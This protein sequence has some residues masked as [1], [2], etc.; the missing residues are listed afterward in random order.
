MITSSHPAFAKLATKLD[1]AGRELSKIDEFLD[2]IRNLGQSAND[3]A[4]GSALALGIHNTTTA[5]KT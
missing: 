5:S 3:W 4:L 2:A 1:R